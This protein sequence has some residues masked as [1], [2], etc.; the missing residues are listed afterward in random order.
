[1]PCD[2]RRSGS[3]YCKLRPG[4]LFAGHDFLDG[5]LPQGTFG[6]RSAVMQFE[7]EK[8]LRAAVTTEPDR[9]SWYFIKP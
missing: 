2:I 6:V 3:W 8:G 7:R 5:E 9:P 1:M 4:G